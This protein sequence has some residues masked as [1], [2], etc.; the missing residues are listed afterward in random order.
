MPAPLQIRLTEEEDQSLY[1]FKFNEE[2]PKRTRERAEAL[3]L[4][5]YGMSVA[6]IASYLDWDEQTVRDTFHR[7][8][9]KGMEGLYEAQG[10]GRPAECSPEDLNYIEQ[11]LEQQRTWDAGQ[12]A[13]KLAQDRKVELSI[14]QVRRVL[15]KTVGFGNVP[16]T[17]QG[18]QKTS[19][20]KRAKK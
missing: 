2:I 18:N 4:S 16:A 12:I 3:R 15:K 7:W 10:R 5:A 11:L 8:W 20:L 19:Q 14:N 17:V 6:Q 1:Q 13:E 9:D